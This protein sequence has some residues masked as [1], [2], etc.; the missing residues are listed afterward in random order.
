[1]NDYWKSLL[2]GINQSLNSP[3]GG[4]RVVYIFYDGE[5]IGLRKQ[6][7]QPDGSWADEQRISYL[8]YLNSGYPFMDET[9]RKLAFAL[10]EFNNDRG[11]SPY[12]SDGEA[13]LPMLIGTDRVYNP[14][15]KQV[16]VKEA[17]PS[18][19]FY[20]N[21][22]H[23]GFFSNVDFD[24]NGYAWPNKVYGDENGDCW[25]IHLDGKL[26]DI[27]EQLRKMDGMPLSEA[28]GVIALSKRLQ[29]YVDVDVS[30]LEKLSECVDVSG[31]SRIIATFWREFDSFLVAFEAAP[32]DGCKLRFPPGKGSDVF[33]ISTSKESLRIHRDLQ[34]E[35]E[36]LDVLNALTGNT[37]RLNLEEL[38]NVLEFLHA[39]PEEYGIFWPRSND[40][41][42]LLGQATK[43]AWDVSLNSRIGWFEMEGTLELRDVQIPLKDILKADLTGDSEFIQMGEKEYLRIS[44]AL[45]KQLLALQSLGE[46]DELAVPKYQAGKLAEVLGMGELPTVRNAEFD[47]QLQL[48]KE[49][50][51]MMPEIPDGL[52]ATLRDYQVEGYIWMC[53]LAHWGAGGCLADDMGLGK[54]V[55]TIAFLLSRKDNGPSLVI[56]PTSVVPGWKSELEH[57]APKLR[58]VIVNDEKDRE[59]AIDKAKAGDVFIAS[60]GILTSSEDLL[61]SREWN[62]IILDEAH[63]IKNRWTK[64]SKAAMELR[65]SSRFILTGTP[66]QNSLAD[67]WNLFQ[68]INPGMLGQYENFKTKYTASDEEEARQRLEMLKSATQPFIL[69]RVKETVLKELPHKTE[70][71][72]LVSLSKE[73]LAYYEQER[74]MIELLVKTEDGVST[75]V[76][77]GLT[78]LRMASCSPAL[79]NAGWAGGCSKLDV[80]QY[81]LEHLLTDDTHLLI[82]SQFTSFLAMVKK[83]LEKMGLDYLYLDGATPLKERARMVE[84]FQRG[85]HK[86]FLISLKAGGLGLNLTA[87]N[88]VILLDPWWN[89]SI[90]EQA[91]DRTYRIGQERD[92]TVLRL[93][94]AQTIEE[95]IVR[96]QEVKRGISDKVLEG[97]ANSGKLTYEEVMDLVKPF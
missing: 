4:S 73:E 9:D 70:L 32:Y 93:I 55:Q 65:S 92:V 24:E 84:Q 86:L 16:C 74:E 13:V 19:T 52:N 18:A 29:P 94:A 80:L 78:K 48:M 35:M 22:D 15:G 62:V 79:Q 68:F 75:T 91:I 54:T 56:A 97:T 85:E 11:R 47:N 89:P 51:E 81:L 26:K 42:K 82:F 1:M 59:S 67:L 33:V 83:R 40:A 43:G 14:Q 72:Y 60:Y 37:G 17:K 57:F 49:A 10:R 28:E 31:G 46:G 53:R 69:R 61:K 8:Q 88:C 63:Q 30:L 20:V 45:K 5:I 36:K 71:D 90:E 50:Y 34:A 96:L 25:V 21:A 7:R 95:K 6:R 3:V 12:R 38:L 41:V 27:M 39:H 23:I 77:E 66:V 64:V 58:P 87:A 76:F 44:K 2:E